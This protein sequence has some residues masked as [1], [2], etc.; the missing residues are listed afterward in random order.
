M[1]SAFR[2][3]IQ[4]L[5]QSAI[6]G[7]TGG[8]LGDLSEQVVYTATTTTDYDP[9]TGTNTR[10]VGVYSFAAV[11]SRFRSTDADSSID[12]RKDMKLI[13]S[14]LDLPVEPTE[15][16]VCSIFGGR[17]FTV[18]RNMGVPGASVWVIHIRES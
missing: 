13:V 2:L 5:I 7:T 3:P 12:I 6:G 17:L 18:Q 11:A 8:I 15:D 10:I 14:A 1:G 9:V 16:D 4:K